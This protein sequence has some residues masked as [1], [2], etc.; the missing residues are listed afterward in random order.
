MCSHAGAWE[1]V[2]PLSDDSVV[3][4]LCKTLDGINKAI[5]RE[6]CSVPDGDAHEKCNLFQLMTICR[7]TRSHGP[8]W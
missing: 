8:P 1:Q 7:S 3:N 5:E 4:R 2:I 6:R